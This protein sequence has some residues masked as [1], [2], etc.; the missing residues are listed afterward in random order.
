[1]LSVGMLTVITTAHIFIIQASSQL[2]QVS[3]VDPF[4]FGRTREFIQID[5]LNIQPLSLNLAKLSAS[6]ER[7][8]SFIYLSI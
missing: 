7:L 6:I 8:K 1:M 4:L 3:Q 5:P 2:C